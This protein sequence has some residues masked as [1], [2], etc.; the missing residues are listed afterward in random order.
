MLLTLTKVETKKQG[1]YTNIYTHFLSAANKE[2][3]VITDINKM[4]EACKEFLRPLNGSDVNLKVK[5][6]INKDGKFWSL[7]DIREATNDDVQQAQAKRSQYNNNKP[8]SNYDNTGIKVGAARNQAIAFLAATKKGFSLDDVDQ[9]AYEILTRQAKMEKNH[10]EGVNPFEDQAEAA[11]EVHNNGD[12]I[13]DE[14][15]SDDIPF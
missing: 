9:V 7:A 13:D 10:R 5:V 2:F 12:A 1:K 3:S 11:N 8:Q 14:Q 4:S 15:F 6:D